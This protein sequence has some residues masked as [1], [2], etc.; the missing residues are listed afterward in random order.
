MQGHVAPRERRA[1]REDLEAEGAALWHPPFTVSPLLAQ[2]P[3]PDPGLGT[4][5][6][7]DHIFLAISGVTNL[8]KVSTAS[9]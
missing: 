6:D 3:Q 1:W 7:Q 8:H 2:P 9:H 4:L 5:E